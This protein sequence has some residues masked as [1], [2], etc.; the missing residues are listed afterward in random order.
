MNVINVFKYFFFRN[1]IDILQ[2]E[3]QLEKQNKLEMVGVVVVVVVALPV[4][5]DLNL[6]LVISYAIYM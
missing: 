4:G 2:R 3:Q 5:S 6:I 1:T